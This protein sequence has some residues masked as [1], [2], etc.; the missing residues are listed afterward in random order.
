MTVSGVFFAA[1]MIAEAA[2]GRPSSTFAIGYIQVPI[3][4]LAVGAVGF[5]I[6]AFVAQQIGRYRPQWEHFINI[7]SPLVVSL[8]LII[9]SV[10]V[11]LSA[12]AGYTN[13]K[14]FEEL[15]KPHVISDNRILSKVSS[16]PF[17]F[18]SFQ[19]SVKTWDLSKESDNLV[20]SLI[21]WMGGADG[22]IPTISWNNRQVTVVS[23]KDIIIIR[24]NARNI[25]QTDLR[26]YNYT[27]ELWAIPV[28]L[29]L[30]EPEYLAVFVN[31]RSTSNRAMV[32]VYNHGG[33]IVYHEIL[34]RKGCEP[35]IRKVTDLKSH[36]ESIEVKT[37]ETF[38][39]VASN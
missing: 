37:H 2:I 22:M 26:K 7:K 34:E 6:G 16:L 39:L 10:G 32:L 38:Y 1:G 13:V 21:V 18:P 36:Q 35:T 12:N 23:E 19:D 14:Y 15:S 9:L 3:A 20:R 30:Q 8:F 31:L 11:Y 27:R 28:R 33:S 25:A 29:H 17:N 24:D 4:A 5:A